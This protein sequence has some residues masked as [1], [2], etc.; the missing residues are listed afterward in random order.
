MGRIDGAT[1]LEFIVVALVFHSR[2]IVLEIELP[3]LVVF[4]EVA[5]CG[6]AIVSA[7]RTAVVLARRG[8]LIFAAGRRPACTTRRKLDSY[9][10]VFCA[11][12]H[13]HF[14]IR[15][16]G[17]IIHF[18]KIRDISSIHNSVLA[19]VCRDYFRV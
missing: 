2:R 14:K 11:L 4:L 16:T 18:P 3:H 13:G 5:T 8:G 1:L 9:P 15:F 7:S 17:L 12:L 6:H 10:V 19:P